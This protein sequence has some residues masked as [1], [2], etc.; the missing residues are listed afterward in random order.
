MADSLLTEYYG[1]QSQALKDRAVLGASVEDFAA[2]PFSLFSN[3]LGRRILECFE[4]AHITPK[5]YATSTGTRISLA[6]CAQRSAAC[7][8]AQMRLVQQRDSLPED[9]NIF[10][11]YADGQPMTQPLELIYRKD[12][13]LSRYSQ[14][15]LELLTQYFSSLEQMHLIRKV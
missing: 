13:Y 9:I 4:A 10:P 3:R 15:F 12:R 1:P 2:L 8:A 6:V 7:F 14:A 11:F 5:T